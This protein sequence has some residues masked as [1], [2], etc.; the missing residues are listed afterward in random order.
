MA[1][2]PHQPQYLSGREQ[3]Q[4][5]ARMRLVPACINVSVSAL[6]VVI[7]AVVCRDGRGCSGCSDKG[8]TCL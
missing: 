5:L 7:A 3:P 2:E 4:H 6:V 8:N 1:R